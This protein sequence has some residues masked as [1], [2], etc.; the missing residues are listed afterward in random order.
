MS[1][2]RVQ[3]QFMGPVKRPGNQNE[4][5][6]ILQP[7]ATVNDLLTSLGYETAHARHLGVFREGVRLPHTSPL[8]S[9]DEITV[10]L[11]V[12]GGL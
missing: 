3:V 12:G 6:V 9:D 1:G 2:V 11:A 8:V 4:M 7:G 10:A 5:S